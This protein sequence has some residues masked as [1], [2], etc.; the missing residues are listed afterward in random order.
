MFGLR[1]WL[2]RKGHG[3][4]I[5]L[6]FG[7]PEVRVDEAR[8][9][10]IFIEGGPARTMIRSAD[11]HGHWHL[12]MYS[13]LWSLTLDG[14]G[15]AHSES[16]D[17]TIGRALQVLNGQALMSVDADPRSG[18]STFTFDLGCVLATRPAA[19]TTSHH[20]PEEQWMLFQPNGQVLAVRDDGRYSLHAG[21]APPDEHRWA[22]I[23]NP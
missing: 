11:V 15:L 3:S 16:D 7:D 2:V 17:R 13:C 10:P 5:T 20:D 4:F 12:W 14:F 22:P 18:S 19:P 1:S 23:P 6:E 9:L 21:S 8:L